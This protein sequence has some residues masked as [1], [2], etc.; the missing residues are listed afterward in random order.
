MPAMALPIPFV[1]I[2]LITAG[3]L[4]DHKVAARNPE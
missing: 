4:H 2:A 3:S 1:F